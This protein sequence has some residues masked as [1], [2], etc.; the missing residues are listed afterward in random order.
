MKA[1]PGTGAK[2][3]N[4]L[5]NN[6]GSSCHC[7]RKRQG[8]QEK[9]NL[10]AA[11]TAFAC[12]ESEEATLL[13]AARKRRFHPT[14][15]LTHNKVLQDHLASNRETWN[16]SV[17]DAHSA[18]FRVVQQESGNYSTWANVILQVGI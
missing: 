4:T 7:K 1:F 5:K 2:K 11:E 13:Y 3:I 17:Q 6:R 9:N 10:C 18:W 15:A 16:Q 14:K 12:W 8:E